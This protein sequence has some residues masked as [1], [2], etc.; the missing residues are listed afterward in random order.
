MVGIF[1]AGLLILAYLRF[2]LETDLLNPLVLGDKRAKIE[3]EY[4]VVGF[5]PTWMVG[6]TMEY[7]Q[8]ID[9][10]VFL[11]VEVDEDGDLIWDLQGKKINSDLYLRQKTKISECGG[12][13]ILGIKQ[14]DDKKLLK[15]VGSKEARENM[16]KQ[17]KKVVEEEG[18][19][20][21][22]VDFEYQNNPFAVLESDFWVL[23]EELREA[24]VGQIS[25]DVFANTVIKGNG[26]GLK[27]LMKMLDDLIVMAYDFHRPSSNYAGPV[28]PIGSR[29]GERNLQEI[30]QKMVDAELEKEKVVLAY[31]LYGY[32][33]ETESDEFRSKTKKWSVMASYA[34]VKELRNNEEVVDGYD[35]VS[36]TP[37]LWY[38]KD[39]EIRQIY[40]ENLNSLRVKM[41][42]ARQVQ[43]DGVGFWALGYEGE[44]AYLWQEMFIKDKFN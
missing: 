12:K 13:N 41:D 40:Y 31:P 36:M 5:L 28:A 42:L 23:L 17:V 26:D 8:E 9:E 3:R 4:K 15:L 14:F 20:G 11:G 1:L 7:C 29:T 37:W 10:L 43:V 22:N 25:L 30:T 21:V 16:V 19:D 2:G 32:E 35:E 38:Q 6:K 33:W 34:R 44:N 39:G 18:F 27:E 24:D